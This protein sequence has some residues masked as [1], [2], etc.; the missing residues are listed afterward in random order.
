MRKDL[1]KSLFLAYF[2]RKSDSRRNLSFTMNLPLKA[3][4][5]FDATARFGSYSQAAKFLCVSHGAVLAQVQKLEAYLGV[6]LFVRHKGRIVLSEAGL[7]LS[8]ATAP[9][10]QMIGAA[11]QELKAV[12]RQTLVLST[13]PSLAAHFLLPNIH[14]FHAVCPE[15]DLELHYCINGQ[16]HPGSHFVLDYHDK[17]LPESPDTYLLFSGASVPVCGNGLKQA[18][19]RG[20][21]VFEDGML[22]HDS[23][24]NY[25]Q[26]WFTHNRPHQ[27]VDCGKGAVYSDFNLLHTAVLCNN[28]IALCPYV[29]LYEDL[30]QGRLHLLSVEKGNTERCYRLTVGE[31]SGGEAQDQM[32]EWLLNLAAA[33]RNAA[34]DYLDS[35]RSSMC[36]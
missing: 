28:G 32:K 4:Q 15:V 19:E 5:Y 34:E 13:I 6:K 29:L 33:R 21:W 10:F 26:Q 24:K 16:Y 36:V 9:A 7:H 2:V 8:R 17:G 3:I 22:L 12:K 1:Y 23:D 31:K 30:N 27:A 35:F 20:D 18:R 25:W 11:V 14:E